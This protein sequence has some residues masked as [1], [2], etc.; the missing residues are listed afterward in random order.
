MVDHVGTFESLSV[1]TFDMYPKYSYSKRA[2]S[3]LIR[4]VIFARQ[5]VFRQDAVAC[6][7]RLKPSLQVLGR[8]NIPQ[9][10]PCVVTINHYYRAGFAAQWMAL[11]VAATIPADMHWVMTG[12]L[13]YPGRLYAS[14]GRALSRFILHRIAGV[15][16][17]TAMPPMPPR[18]EDTVERAAA[19][20]AVLDVVKSSKA[21]PIIGLAPEGG[22]SVDGRLVRPASGLGRFGLLLSS[23]GLKFVPV[24][25]YEAERVFSLH[26]GAPYEL[27]VPHDLPA[28]DKDA[29]AARAI[30]EHIAQLLPSHLRGEFA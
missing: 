4:D 8:E 12:E 10:G 21:P 6:I 23:A 2:I 29:L 19:V 7:E 18:P 20:R 3:G 24:G 13:T 28:G 16:G 30:M 1:P 5:R 14:P 22:D 17:F 15:Y 9:R 26:F 11:A 27:S 25:A